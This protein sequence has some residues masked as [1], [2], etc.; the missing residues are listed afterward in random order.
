MLIRAALDL[1]SWKLRPR[2]YQR[3]VPPVLVTESVASPDVLPGSQR[4]SSSKGQNRRKTAT[5]SYGPLATGPVARL[6]A[7]V[8]ELPN[9]LNEGEEPV[10][11]AELPWGSSVL[12]SGTS[13]NGVPRVLACCFIRTSPRREQGLTLARAAGCWRGRVEKRGERVR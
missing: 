3:T 11:P 7:V 5:Q 1:L 13:H 4:L 9:G 12:D 10:R 2:L 6:S 8:A